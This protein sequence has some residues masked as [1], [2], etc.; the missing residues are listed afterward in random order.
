[1][2]CNRQFSVH[3]EEKESKIRN[4]NINLSKGSVLVALL[5]N[6]YTSTPETVSCHFVHANDIALA[7]KRKSFE[8]FPEML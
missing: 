6:L 8:E 3:I 1:M 7:A 2:L 4:L 5:I